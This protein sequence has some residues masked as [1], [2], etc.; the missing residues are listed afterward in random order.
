M[1]AYPPMPLAGWL[2]LEGWTIA[3]GATSYGLRNDIV[4]LLVFFDTYGRQAH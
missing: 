3:C 1:R 4:Y 2:A